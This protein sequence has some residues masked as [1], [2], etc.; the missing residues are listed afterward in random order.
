MW[1]EGLGALQCISSV[2][3][4]PYIILIAVSEPMGQFPIMQLIR[5]DLQLNP[6]CMYTHA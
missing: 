3:V 6:G 5:G 4:L 2:P 1:K